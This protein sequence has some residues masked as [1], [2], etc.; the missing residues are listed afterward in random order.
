MLSSEEFSKQFRRELI[1]A[2]CCIS[3]FGDYAGPLKH[4][5]FGDGKAAVVGSQWNEGAF[6]SV[7]ADT[8]I[9]LGMN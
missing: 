1:Q 2:P 7:F 3:C 8:S 6:D 4:V 5:F 9:G